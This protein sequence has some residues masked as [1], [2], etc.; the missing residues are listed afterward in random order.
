MWYLQL[1][2]DSPSQLLNSAEPMPG[3]IIYSE[4]ADELS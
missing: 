1:H 3:Q 2:V 4:D